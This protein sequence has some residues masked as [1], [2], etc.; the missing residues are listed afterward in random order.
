VLNTITHS[1][2]NETNKKS[3]K[4]QIKL[5]YSSYTSRLQDGIP[6]VGPTRGHEEQEAN[7][8]RARTLATHR[9]LRTVAPEA[10]RILG[11]PPQRHLVVQQALVARRMRAGR[12]QEA[13][14]IQPVLHRH[15]HDVGH[16][17]DCAAVDVVA[18]AAQKAAAVNV[19]EH[20]L[21]RP[22]P[23]QVAVLLHIDVQ[24]QAVL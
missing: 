6:E 2:S 10:A 24:V 9:H 11:H 3:S 14:R 12:V 5:T 20:G 1:D 22:A 21:Q 23:V 4:K 18:R 19:D 17:G 8:P 16:G 7:S 13:E 15:H